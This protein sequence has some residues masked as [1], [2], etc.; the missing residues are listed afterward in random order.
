MKNKLSKPNKIG[1][2]VHYIE[3]IM[4]DF[5]QGFSIDH[6]TDHFE[7][8]RSDVEYVIR[9]VLANYKESSIERLKL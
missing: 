7:I 5:L 6:I 3:G 4:V 8:D 2:E 9:L 1:F